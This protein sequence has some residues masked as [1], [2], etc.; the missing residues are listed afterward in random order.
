MGGETIVSCC[1][2]D[3]LSLCN[4]RRRR[5]G[6]DRGGVGRG[7]RQKMRIW[8]Q[9]TLAAIRYAIIKGKNP[10]HA[11]QSAPSSSGKPASRTHSP[12]EYCAR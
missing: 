11:I 1:I 2:L 8:R 9:N 6:R 10:T 4:F 5:R 3:G 12:E 7:I